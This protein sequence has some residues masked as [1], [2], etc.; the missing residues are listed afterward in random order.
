MFM[1]ALE[2]ANQPTLGVPRLPVAYEWDLCLGKKPWRQ[3]DQDDVDRCFGDSFGTVCI[4]LEPPEANTLYHCPVE[5]APVLAR[6]AQI[7]T[8]AAR[9]NRSVLL[10]NAPHVPDAYITAKAN[11]MAV[12]AS[13]S[14][15]RESGIVGATGGTCFD[16]YRG[17]AAEWPAY[18]A[19]LAANVNLARAHGKPL[20]VFMGRLDRAGDPLPLEL[21]RSDLYRVADLLRPHDSIVLWAARGRTGPDGAWAPDPWDPSQGWLQVAADVVRNVDAVELF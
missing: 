21:F 2:F 4:D 8:M 10:Y 9:E 3:I 6:M 14:L 16:L 11:S 18:D 15:M 1:H 20:F 12:P 13:W 17:P 5:S 19:G 7:A